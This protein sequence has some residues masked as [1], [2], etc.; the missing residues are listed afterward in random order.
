MNKI[1]GLLKAWGAE[2]WI[3]PAIKQAL[4]YCDEVIVAIGAYTP[5]LGEFED[6]TYNI[7]KEYRD[8]KLLKYE[9]SKQYVC[10]A[11]ADAHNN[12]LKHS[13]LHEQGNWLWILDVDEFYPGSAY[14]EIK[15]II[16]SNKYDFIRVEEKFFFINMQH[17]LEAS[18]GRLIRVEDTK[19][20]FVSVNDWSRKPKTPYLLSRRTGMFHYSMLADTRIHRVRWE[21]EYPGTAQPHKVKWLDKIYPNYEFEKEDYWIEQNLKMFGIKSPWFNKGM[22]PNEDGKL[23]IYTGQHPKFI[24]EIGYPKVKDFRK[25][26][27]VK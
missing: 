16:E 23:F 6:D 12:M 13:E 15:T 9:V 4:E 22:T 2:D 3:R 21:T 11:V 8:I 17:Y 26:Y 24:E 10:Q 19:D 7:C 25:F 27:D 18:H 5:Q 14:E 1:I 20:F